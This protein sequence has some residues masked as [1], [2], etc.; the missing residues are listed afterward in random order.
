MHR[1]VPKLAESLSPFHSTPVLLRLRGLPET[2][3]GSIAVPEPSPCDAVTAWAGVRG[4]PSG[5]TFCRN[6]QNCRCS[7]PRNS[8]SFCRSF[9]A[10]ALEFQLLDRGRLQQCCIVDGDV[11]S[12]RGC[13]P[14]RATLQNDKIK[15]HT[16]MAGEVEPSLVSAVENKGLAPEQLLLLEY[17]SDRSANGR[18]N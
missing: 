16:V 8:G 13:A 5:S 18:G 11:F 6:P 15:T 9:S 4:R 10:T 1:R 12:V 17:L 14:T 7:G 3:Y 2:F